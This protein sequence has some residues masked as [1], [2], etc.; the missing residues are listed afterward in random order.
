MV[1]KKTIMRKINELNILV[2]GE[3]LLLLV[4]TLG[5]LGYFSHKTLKQEALHNAEQ[6]LEGTMQHIDNILLSVEQATGNIYY[7]LIE[8]LNDSSRM[9]TYSRKLVES[10]S[11][12]DG[13]AICFRPGYYP[14]KDLF[15]AYVHHK[16]HNS[17]NPSDLIISQTFANRPY[18]EQI[19]YTRSMNTGWIGWIDPL[20]GDC[21]EDEPLVTF[22]LPF[23]D[24]NDKRIGV[25]AVDVAI[26]QLSKI[27]L[28]AKPSNNGY[29]VLLGHNG[30][31]IV[32]P[33]KEKLF[34]PKIF[35][36]SNRNAHPSELE[37][38][39]AMLA[40][41]KG[42]KEFRRDGSDWWV[43][44]KPFS[45][46]KWAERSSIEV[47]WSVGVVYPE[48]D[49]FGLHNMLL[50]LVVGIAIAGF[51]LQFLLW[52]WIIRKQMNPLKML[53]KSAQHI[54]QGNYNETLPYPERSDEIGLLQSR[55]YKMQRALQGEVSEAEEETIRLRLQ[56]EMM[57]AEY[58]QVIDANELKSSFLHYMT[59]QMVAPSESI[60]S[61]ATVL[62]IKGD[63]DEETKGKEADNI[64][65]KSQTMV[66]LLSHTA[67][68]TATETKKGGKS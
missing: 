34:N 8:H 53:A 39:K 35:S 59:H 4:V 46:V 25:I 62:C 18:T 66:D 51:L 30:T 11:Y 64:Q 63:S 50:Y 40:G 65:R 21:T 52:R 6:T 55:L 23:N 33:D 15:M 37:A 48:N 67:H 36:Q 17:N 31:Y 12:I 27:I 5:I 13:C 45:P 2:I 60:D 56:G 10:N 57:R 44:Y 16:T 68:F 28:A 20:K 14:G 54:A 3:A 47:N 22:C 38:A 58:E 32:Q 1:L 43:F 49:I 26:T 41:E 61:S 24:K 29:S 7:D 19:W 9:Y 42:M